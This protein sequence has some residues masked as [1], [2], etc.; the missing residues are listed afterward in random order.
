MMK[1]SG[2]QA[3]K[4]PRG[5]RKT[6][7]ANSPRGKHIRH[8]QGLCGRGKHCPETVNRVVKEPVRITT[9]WEEKHYSE[10]ETDG[11]RGKV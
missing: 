11:S 7:I 8:D 1:R 9:A 4:K 2:F 5:R 6:Q 10:T 3:A